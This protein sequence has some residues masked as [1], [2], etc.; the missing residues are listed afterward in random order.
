[1][2]INIALQKLANEAEESQKKA[3]TFNMA[4]EVLRETFA[5]QFV[6]L[7]AA[8]AQIADLTQQLTDKE[9]ELQTVQQQLFQATNGGLNTPPITPPL[10]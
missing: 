1:M 8:N 10:Q 9:A 3:D 7:D 6:Q 4:Q 2:D 5:P